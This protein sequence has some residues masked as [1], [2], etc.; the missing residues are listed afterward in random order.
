M[1]LSCV[2][3]ERDMKVLRGGSSRGWTVPSSA[4]PGDVVIGYKPGA[5]AG[6]RGTRKGPFEVFVAAGIVYGRP[7]RLGS[8]L[9]NAPIAEVETFPNPLP[10]KV[11][12]DG[13][14]LGTQP[15][16]RSC[17]ASASS[18]TLWTGFHDRAARRRK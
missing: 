1:S 9:Y 3:R 11:L 5:E 15:M 10:R 16:A 12:T 13:R 17:V 6:Y 18:G 2:A 8:R 4:R 7:T 14:S